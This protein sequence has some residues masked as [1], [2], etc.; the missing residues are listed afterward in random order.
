MKLKENQS[1]SP[2]SVKSLVVTF[3]LILL[4]GWATYRRINV[5]SLDLLDFY[6]AYY[7][8]G[9]L[10]LENPNILYSFAKSIVLGFVNLPIIAYLFTPFSL[11]DKYPSGF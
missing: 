7:P 6:N 11:I 10:I 9:R 2:R 5:E 8:A 4:I 3:V 1:L